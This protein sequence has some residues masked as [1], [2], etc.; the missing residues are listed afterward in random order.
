MKR[1]NILNALV[2]STIARMKMSSYRKNV[3][4]RDVKFT[5]LGDGSG[6]GRRVVRLVVTLV[7]RTLPVLRRQLVLYLISR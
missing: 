7:P 2:E 3:L 5:I 6:G 4:S 1:I